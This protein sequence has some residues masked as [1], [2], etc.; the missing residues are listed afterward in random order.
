M[1]C[2][3]VGDHV[4]FISF[5]LSFP[6]FFYKNSNFLEFSSTF[7]QFYRLPDFSKF[8][9]TFQVFG[10][11][12]VFK[13]YITCLYTSEVWTFF[14]IN[15][16]LQNGLK[17]YRF[18]NLNQFRLSDKFPTKWY[19]V[20]LKLSTLHFRMVATWSLCTCMI[21]IFKEGAGVAVKDVSSAVVRGHKGI[22]AKTS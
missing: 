17:F 1:E 2:N 19:E 6:H 11:P 15:S 20:R 13:W 14:V 22:F 3:T 21:K 10:H 18:L 5:A 9:F 4:T 8:F 12:E 7:W 16:M